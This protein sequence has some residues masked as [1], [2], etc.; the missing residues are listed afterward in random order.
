MYY[1]G[2]GRKNDRIRERNMFGSGF[3]S[4]IKRPASA[5]L[6]RRMPIGLLIAM[7]YNYKEL[8]DLNIVPIF[9]KLNAVEKI[10]LQYKLNPM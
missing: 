1:P 2:S 9:G 5:T 8:K 7:H 6:D 3:G 4:G 10:I